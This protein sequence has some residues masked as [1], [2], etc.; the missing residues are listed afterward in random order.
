MDDVVVGVANEKREDAGAAV[1]VNVVVV[2]GVAEKENPDGTPVEEGIVA[3]VVDGVE[4]EKREVDGAATVA[5]VVA[6]GTPPNEKLD[7]IG[8]A[9]VVATGAKDVAAGLVGVKRD[10][11][12]KPPEAGVAVAVCPKEIG[13]VVLVPNGAVVDEPA[14]KVNDDD[15]DCIALG[16]RA[17]VV[18]GAEPNANVDG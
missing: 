14:P 17:A 2:A 15:D 9:V 10:V 18:A 1:A 12:E 16:N 6:V 4:N 7:E 13:A 5:V 8:A 3:V 11:A